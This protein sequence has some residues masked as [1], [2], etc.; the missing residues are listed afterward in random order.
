MI[1]NPKSC[2]SAREFARIYPYTVAQMLS[3]SLVESHVLPGNHHVCC[4]ISQNFYEFWFQQK[5]PWAHIF[6]Y[7]ISPSFRKARRVVQ[8][9]KAFVMRVRLDPRIVGFFRNVGIRTGHPQGIPLKKIQQLDPEHSNFMIF[10]ANFKWERCG[11]LSSKTSKAPFGRV[12]LLIWRMVNHTIG[13][14]SQQLL[15]WF[16]WDLKHHTTA[17]AVWC[18][19]YNVW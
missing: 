7:P 16:Y 3:P 17:M 6:P 14:V 18:H 19:V 11:N 1:R 5:H 15:I 13:A 2:W 9:Y 4:M 10:Y 12:E 8:Q